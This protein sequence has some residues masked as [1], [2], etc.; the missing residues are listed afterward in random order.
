MICFS[1]LATAF[2]DGSFVMKTRVTLLLVMAGGL[3][4]WSADTSRSGAPVFIGQPTV[5]WV[6]GEWQTWKDGVWTPYGQKADQSGRTAGESI[7]RGE[8]DHG[9]VRPQN[10]QSRRG[11]HQNYPGGD[12]G[13]AGAETGRSYDRADQPNI[14]IG[15]TTIRMGR[16]NVAIGQ[17]NGIGQPNAGLGQQN[18]SIGQTTIGSG[19][20]NEG[21][22][23]PNG[24]GRTTIGIGRP[25]TGIGQ[26]HG[27]GQPAI[28][29]GKQ[30]EFIK[31]E[32]EPRR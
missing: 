9:D 22:G 29:I 24:M 21:M 6:N 32:R 1:R 19:Q 8:H 27:I 15:E 17:P 10:T 5:Y 2:G 14:A 23:Q 11:R 13:S 4:C 16:P 28:G 26:P 7:S 20:Q 12:N 3:C 31:Q 18:T 25:N 30:S